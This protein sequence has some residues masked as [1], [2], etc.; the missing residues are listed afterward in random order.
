MS[1]AQQLQLEYPANA[2]IQSMLNLRPDDST[3]KRLHELI[4][5]QQMGTLP[6]SH[7]PP[8]LGPL[9]TFRDSFY[10]GW[11]ELPLTEFIEHDTGLDHAW[12]ESFSIALLC[13]SIQNYEAAKLDEKK[14]DAFVAE[15]KKAIHGSLYLFYGRVLTKF[16]PLETLLSDLKQQRLGA[17]PKDMFREA[18]LHNAARWTQWFAEGWWTDRDW[19]LFNNY[20]KYIALGACES[21]VEGLIEQL[22]RDGC[23][24]P[25]SVGKG[26][27]GWC[28]YIRYLDGQP[29]FDHSCIDQIVKKTVMAD[30]I[31]YHTTP[32][33][34]SSGREKESFY[35][36]R[37]F[38]EKK[39]PGEMF[40]K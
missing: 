7:A 25:A 20:A 6:G 19:D 33:P 23:P 10:R 1:A 3:G 38:V 30:L 9:E 27:D 40:R 21:E 31:W 35:Y 13:Q 29:S 36:S 5:S 18:M 14:I 34:G 26:K 15:K 17:E 28:S 8:P 4:V 12:W 2:T 22:T 37:K 16:P 11:H 32:R 39:Q 24:I